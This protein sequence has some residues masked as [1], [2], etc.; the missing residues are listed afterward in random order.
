MEIKVIVFLLIAFFS[1]IQ[2]LTKGAK[3][4]EQKAQQAARRPAADPAR[5]QRVQSEIE[6]FLSEVT[7]KRPVSADT[8]EAEARERR[9][10]AAEAKRLRQ[11]EAKRKQAETERRR[12]VK[13]ARRQS[14]AAQDRLNHLKS[15]VSDH[16]AAYLDDDVREHVDSSIISSVNSHL[17]DRDLE[18]PAGLIG[19]VSDGRNRA[20]E[21]VRAL[22]TDPS[23][24]RNAILINEILSRPRSLR[25]R[26]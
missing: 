19:G 25:R 23:G 16:V 2:S 11:E 20:A 13:E 22:L 9:R 4:K 5:R 21:S 7:G 15:G 17:G 12:Q 18:M 3:E 6:S 10:K 26:S 14:A 24:I 8:A 1:M